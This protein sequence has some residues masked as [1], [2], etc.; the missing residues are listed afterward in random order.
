M[1][2][3]HKNTCW[4]LQWHIT[5]MVDVA[6]EVGADD[7]SHGFTGEGNDQVRFELTFFA[8]NPELSVIAPRRE[9]E[10]KGTEDAIE[11]A[12]RHNVPVPVT[13]ESIYSRYRNLWHLSH[14]GIHELEGL[15]QKANWPRLAEHVN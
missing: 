14:E 2:S 13:K 11:Y 9:W 8:L 6:K 5:A 10:I 12:V 7:V 15:E 4:G 1:L 3:I